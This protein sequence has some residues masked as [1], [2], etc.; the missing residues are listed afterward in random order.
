MAEHLV[1]I[2]GTEKDKVNCPFYYKIGACRHGD[3]CSRIHNKPLFSQTILLTNLYTS[4]EQITAA[5]R[6][7][8]MPDPDIPEEERKYHF[9]DFYDDIRE[10]M[11]KFGKVES[12]NV[13]EN[14]SEHLAG[15]TYVKFVDEASASTAMRTIMG[16]YYAG[17]IVAAEFSPVTDFREGK[18]RPFEK[19]GACQHGDY[20]HF[21]HLRRHPANVPPGPPR[22]D[23]RGGRRY[24][25]DDRERDRDR[26]SRDWDHR[27][28]S[29]DRD[30]SFDRKRGSRDRDR[31]RER[32]RDRDRSYEYE[33]GRRDTPREYEQPRNGVKREYEATREDGMRD[34]GEGGDVKREYDYERGD[35]KREKSVE[36]EGEA[37]RHRDRERDRD[38]EHRRYSDRD[39]GRERRHRDRGRDS[40]RGRDRGGERDRERD[41]GRYKDYDRGD[42]RLSYRERRGSSDKRYD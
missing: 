19:Q 8:G 39:S 16:R 14:K 2:Y 5:A 15:N 4:P 40:E 20:C 27:R 29:R 26:K 10:E 18:C 25:R 3:R 42:E 30:R 13:C 1:S 12:V 31:R 23:D 21:M 9:D 6:A 33:R 11:E 22:H 36:H 28:S 38:R 35:V 41:Q 34:G 37:S 17:R 24:H 32:S 7:Q